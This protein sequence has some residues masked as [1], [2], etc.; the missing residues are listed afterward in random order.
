MQFQDKSPRFSKTVSPPASKKFQRD[1]GIG[2]TF[3]QEMLTFL[4]G[5][6]ANKSS[7]SSSSKEEEEDIYEDL[8]GP[9]MA[10]PAIPEKSDET[11]PPSRESLKA[12]NKHSYENHVITMKQQSNN[13]HDVSKGQNN[14]E[15]DKNRCNSACQVQNDHELRDARSNTWPTQQNYDNHKLKNIDSVFSG[16]CCYDN[17][18]L[19]PSADNARPS[20]DACYDNWKIK[21]TAGKSE[22]TSSKMN[23]PLSE[24]QIS[25]NLKPCYENVE[26][27]NGKLAVNNGELPHKT[28]SSRKSEQDISPN[29]G[30]TTEQSYENCILNSTQMSY[31]NIIPKLL[32]NGDLTHDQ[33][34]GDSIYENCETEGKEKENSE[35]ILGIAIP[36]CKDQND[37]N[38]RKLCHSLP[39]N[40]H[41]VGVVPGDLHGFLNMILEKR[42]RPALTRVGSADAIPVLRNDAEKG[43]NLSISATSNSGDNLD[44]QDHPI[45]PPRWKRLARLKRTQSLTCCPQHRW[46]MTVSPELA[47]VLS[48]RLNGTVVSTS[49]GFKQ[50]AKL[51]NGSHL[52]ASEADKPCLPPRANNRNSVTT[53]PR[54]TSRNAYENFM[55]PSHLSLQETSPPELPPKLQRSNEKA[56]FQNTTRRART[57]HYENVDG[58]HGFHV[59]GS[60][61]VVSQ[62]VSDSSP[63]PLPRKLS[64]T[65]TPPMIPC[66]VD[67][68]Q[69]C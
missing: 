21:N 31:E 11:T 17:H 59:V 49:A 2:E 38:D 32:Q 35:E 20:S 56:S 69:K 29:Q 9:F 51:I 41:C 39:T 37:S 48:K 54:S 22:G 12:H 58:V 18:K 23:E 10:V 53:T 27:Q 47:T 34:N 19:R 33:E 60:Q 4:K 65:K 68:E 7:V 40:C 66:R 6:G 28:V 55:L 30:R 24:K 25:E 26:L 45:P 50:G 52:E 43:D 44:D 5:V 16:N 57:L 14:H 13:K 64:Q 1:S 36:R 67:L 62:I 46:E 63:P 61:H 42:N 15:S 8:T 3:A